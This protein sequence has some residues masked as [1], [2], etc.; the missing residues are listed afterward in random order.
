[1]TCLV[2]EKASIYANRCFFSII[3][4]LFISENFLIQ[5]II[6]YGSEEWNLKNKVSP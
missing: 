1:M 2:A 6:N 4:D 5:K 3:L